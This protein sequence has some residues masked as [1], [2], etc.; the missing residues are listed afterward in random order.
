MPGF[1]PDFSH[2]ISVSEPDSHTAFHF[3]IITFVT[4]VNRQFQH[5]SVDTATARC[6]VSKPQ[7]QNKGNCTMKTVNN[8]TVSDV[9]D[10]LEGFK[11]QMQAKGLTNITTLDFWVQDGDDNLVYLSYRSA[12]M[13]GSEQFRAEG[14]DALA[15]AESWLENLPTVEQQKRNAFLKKL[16]ECVE[17]GRQNGIEVELINPLQKMMETLSE[18][19]VTFQPAPLGSPP[20]HMPF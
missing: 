14:I 11:V 19:C 17:I 2:L 6:N 20:E 9:K 3:K 16:A 1:E 5:L 18:G 10:W 13:P 4:L 15:L 7:T 8:Y 12:G